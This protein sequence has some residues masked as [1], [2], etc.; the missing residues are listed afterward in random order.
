MIKT[1]T[2]PDKFSIIDTSSSC[3]IG[4]LKIALRRA[5]RVPITLQRI[6]DLHANQLSTSRTLS[7]CGVQ[8]GD[9]L[10]MVKQGS[11][12]CEFDC[13]TC[14]AAWARLAG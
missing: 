11:G 13:V 8:E 14:S 5:L 6:Y 9:V 4:Y 7:H 10:F 12:E 1:G 2:K 3:T